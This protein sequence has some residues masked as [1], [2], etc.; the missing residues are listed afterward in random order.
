MG[1]FEKQRSLA[2]HDALSL[3]AVIQLIA[4]NIVAVALYDERVSGVQSVGVILGVM[5]VAL[6]TLGASDS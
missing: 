3:S 1:R 6:I 4:V 2:I 5:A